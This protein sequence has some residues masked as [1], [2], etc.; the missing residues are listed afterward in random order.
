[1]T[2]HNFQSPDARMPA[3]GHIPDFEGKTVEHTKAKIV[4]VGRLDINDEVYRMDDSIKVLVECRVEGIDHK[5]NADGDL[6]RVHLLKAL[7]AVVVSWDMDLDGL[8]KAL[9][10]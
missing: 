10:S 3:P 4:S 2:I 1:M 7:D 5:V 6:E 8:K 9:E